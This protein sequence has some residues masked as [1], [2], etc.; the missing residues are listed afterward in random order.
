M[1]APIEVLWEFP[2]Q[3]KLVHRIVLGLQNNDELNFGVGDFWSY[4]FPYSKKEAEFERLIDAW[5]ECRARVIPRPGWLFRTLELQVLDSG[6]WTKAYGAGSITFQK[7]DPAILS[8]A[9][10]S[11]T[12]ERV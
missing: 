12:E 5:V 4:F 8:N 7:C 11:L 1:D 9:M 3:A 10:N 2:V 6:E